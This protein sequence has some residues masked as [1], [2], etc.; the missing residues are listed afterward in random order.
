MV[1]KLG[2]ERTPYAEAWATLLAAGIDYRAGNVERARAGLM[3]GIRTSARAELNM[4]AAS[5]QL[6]LGLMIG[7]DEGV[8]MTSQAMSAMSRQGI[9]NAAAFAR[10]LVPGFGL[11]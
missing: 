9:R 4:C 3:A 6:A 1:R 10:M 5:A 7:G 8:G 2:Q 11:S